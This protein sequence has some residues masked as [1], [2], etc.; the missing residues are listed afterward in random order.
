MKLVRDHIG[1]IPWREE[2]GGEQAKERLGWIETDSQEYHDLLRNKLRE[3]VGELLDAMTKLQ[4]IEEAADVFEVLRAFLVANRIALPSD[5]EPLLVRA[6]NAKLAERGGYF[7][8][9][10]FH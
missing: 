6:A 2:S 1:D 8:G 10:T 3:E 4:I 7:A 9:R 5:A